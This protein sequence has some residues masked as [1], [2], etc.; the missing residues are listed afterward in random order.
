VVPAA[1][2]RTVEAWAYLAWYGSPAHSVAD[3]LDGTSG[4]N[5]YRIS[6]LREAAPWRALLGT[7]QADAYLSTLRESLGAPEIARDLRLPG[8]RAYIAALDAQLDRVMAGEVGPEEGLR[9]AAR[10]WELI[11]DR[12]GRD[13]QRRHYRAAMGLGAGE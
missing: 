4:I 2:P 6:R 8:Y 13:G 9:A 3:V 10:D 12:L 1:S 11:T 7:T 5:P